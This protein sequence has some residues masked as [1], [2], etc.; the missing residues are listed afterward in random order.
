MKAVVLSTSLNPASRSAILAEHAHERLREQG[1]EAELIDLRQNPLPFC[2]GGEAYGDARVQALT[3][4]LQPVDLFLVATPI[5]NYDANAALK[6]LI[7]LTGSDVWEDKVAGFLCAAGGQGSYMSIMGL[8]NSLML[9]FR[10]LVLPR[11]V[12]ATGKDFRAGKI[13]SD[14]VRDRVH[15]LVSSGIKVAEALRG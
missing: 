4:K 15:E 12:Y 13:E 3:E 9:D 8:I 5:Y 10:T 7:E 11:Y 6:N 14:E 1:I 2:D